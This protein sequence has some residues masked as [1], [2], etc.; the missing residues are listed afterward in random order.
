MSDFASNGAAP[1]EEWT[2]AA[3]QLLAEEIA[4]ESGVELTAEELDVEVPVAFGDDVATASWT[5][6]GSVRVHVEG[7]AGPLY[8]WVRLW[9]G[10]RE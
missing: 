8:E 3:E 10:D 9:R 7:H 6:D 4:S 1:P 2:D 5:F